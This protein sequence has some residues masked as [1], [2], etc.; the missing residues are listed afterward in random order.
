MDNWRMHAACRDEDPDLFFPIGSTGPALVQ[1]E[2]AKAVCAT[3][4]VREQCL[5]WAL[6][7]GQDSGVWGGLG[8][9]ERRALKRRARRHV[10]AQG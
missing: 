10:R 1:T 4:P 3:C 5:E 7:N 9:N 2:D 6:E 8:E